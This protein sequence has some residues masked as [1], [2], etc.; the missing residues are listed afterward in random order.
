MLLAVVPAVD[1]VDSCG[2][3]AVDAIDGRGV[4]GGDQSVVRM[5]CA[6]ST[7]LSP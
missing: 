5:A 3:V 7:A 6:S 4:A 2:T 1:A